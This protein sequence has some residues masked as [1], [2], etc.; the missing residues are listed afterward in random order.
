[1][2]M[3]FT[4]NNMNTEKDMKQYLKAKNISLSVEKIQNLIIEYDNNNN[5]NLVFK[6]FSNILKNAKKPED[7]LKIFKRFDKNNN[8]VLT[9]YELKVMLCEL[10][11]NQCTLKDADDIIKKLTIN[12]NQ[13]TYEDFKKIALL[14]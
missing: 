4:K 14:E 5:S 10:T 1:M 12:G 13:I 11:F 2:A 6:D 9:K 7:L 3:E 8:N